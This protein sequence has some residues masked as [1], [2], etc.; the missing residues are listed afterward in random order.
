MIIRITDDAKTYLATKKENHITVDYYVPAASCV[1][2]VVRDPRVN[3]GEPKA[4]GAYI[5]FET[6]EGII[7]HFNRVVLLP[8][9]PNAVI[10][11]GHEKTLFVHQLTI[12]GLSA[13]DDTK[14]QLMD[15]A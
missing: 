6:E 11:I 3:L 13:W 12:K 10:E 15:Q 14:D 8:E 9:D 2:G 7:V 1:A 5:K 4:A